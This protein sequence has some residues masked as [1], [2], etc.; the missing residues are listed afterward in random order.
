MK[1]SS[2][3]ISDLSV[4]HLGSWMNHHNIKPDIFGDGHGKQIVFSVKQLNFS[5]REELRNLLDFKVIIE[6][7]QD[8]VLREREKWTICDKMTGEKSVNHLCA[9]EL[10]ESPNE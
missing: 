4:R 10:F 7:H 6:N 3:P 8:I 1:T 9:G 2:S 5:Q